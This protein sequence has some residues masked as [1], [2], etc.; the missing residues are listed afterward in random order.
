PGSGWDGDIALV[1][2]IAVDP[3][4]LTLD[5]RPTAINEKPQSWI[6]AQV[7]GANAAEQERLRDGAKLKVGTDGLLLLDPSRP[8]IDLAGIS[9]NYSALRATLHW[10]FT[11]E[12]NAIVDWLAVLHPDWDDD[13]LF[14][15]ARR[16]NCGQMVGIHTTEWTEDL[17]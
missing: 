3:T 6:M 8:G 2:R 15:L 12:H 5:G 4:R 17:L 9:N 10:L 14:D 11:M 7:Y 16:T 1:D 13:T